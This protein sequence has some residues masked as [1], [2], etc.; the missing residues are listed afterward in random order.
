MRSCPEQ[1][2]LLLSVP[3]ACRALGIGRTAFYALLVNEGEIELVKLGRR[4]LVRVT[5]LKDLVERLPARKNRSELLRGQGS[6]LTAPPALRAR[7]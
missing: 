1:A 6:D 4:S 2:R 5:D 7:V 3:E